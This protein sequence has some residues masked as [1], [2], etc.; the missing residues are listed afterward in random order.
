M[1]P[2]DG[3]VDFVEVFRA[4]GDI[5]YEGAMV[6]ELEKHCFKGYSKPIDEGIQRFRDM[7]IDF[8]GQS[9]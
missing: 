3:E 4:L 1:L 7:M 5:S 2:G 8:C 6:L 9:S